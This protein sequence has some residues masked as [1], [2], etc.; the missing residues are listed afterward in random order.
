MTPSKGR[1]PQRVAARMAAP[2]VGAV[3]APAARERLGLV[4]YLHGFDNCVENVARPTAGEC[5]PGGEHCPSADLI[6]HLDRSGKA[7][8]LLLP[9]VSYH[10]KSADPGELGRPGAL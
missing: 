4:V 5:L 9:E 6:G 3:A 2:S 7:A 10:R 8:L 1:T